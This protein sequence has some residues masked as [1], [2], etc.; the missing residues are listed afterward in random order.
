MTTHTPI[1][2]W[3]RVSVRDVTT[4]GISLRVFEHGEGRPDRPPVVLCHG[5]PELAFSWRHQVLALAEAGYRVLV[6][7]M[8]GYGGS[9]RPDDVDAYDILTLCADLAGLLDDVGADDAVF[10]GHDWGASVVW[11]MALIHPER[12]RAVVGMSVPATPRA[13]APPL[14]ILRS[15]NGDDFYIVWFQEPGVADRALSRNVRRTLVTREIY[16]AEWAAKPDEQLPPPRWLGDEEL[17][18]YVKTFEETGFTGGLNYY[19]NLDRNWTLTE[20]LDGHL[21]TQPSLF[22]TGSKDPVG[23]FMPAHGLDRVLTDLRGH[24]VLDG[25]GH[26]IQQERP[27]E[28]NAALIEFLSTLG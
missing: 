27:E 7:D 14:P 26:W 1:A 6:P 23:K 22:V 16:S 18:Y 11:N 28:V 21:V 15:R 2:D 9:S 13:P 12:V 10:V 19:R 5:F 17:T 20:H 4:N 3:E 24:V 8:R 25:A